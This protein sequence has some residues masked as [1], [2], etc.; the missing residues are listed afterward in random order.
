M[1]YLISYALKT[2][3]S[4]SKYLMYIFQKS[5]LCVELLVPMFSGQFFFG[6]SVLLLN[7]ALSHGN[8]RSINHVLR[9]V[10]RLF[11]RRSEE[12]FLDVKKS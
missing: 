5:V 3:L 7:Q 4:D 6:R 2:C 9:L 12:L 11:R 8:V 1:E 10:H